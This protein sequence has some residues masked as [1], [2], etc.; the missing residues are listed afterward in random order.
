M[1]LLLFVALSLAF[2]GPS[3][4]VDEAVEERAATGFKQ[5]KTPENA[6]LRSVEKWTLPSL[7]DDR[8]LGNFSHSQANF[9]KGLAATTPAA[10]SGKLGPTGRV[11]LKVLGGTVAGIGSAL[12]AIYLLLATSDWC[13]EDWCSEEQDEESLEESLGAGV[14]LLSFPAGIAVGVSAFYR[15]DRFIYPLAAS[16]LG[17]GAGVAIDM[18]IAKG[19]LFVG[20]MGWLPLI[21]A[22]VASERSREQPESRRYSIGLRPE[23]GRGLSAVAALRF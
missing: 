10:S 20:A 2:V 23:P 11:A 13:G 12:A 5:P 15:D 9:A 6:P 4:A 22:T 3:L 18:A 17:F 21:A 19:G 8:F 1:N 7:G 14:I 16:V